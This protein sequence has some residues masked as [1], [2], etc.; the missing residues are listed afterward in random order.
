MPLRAAQPEDCLPNAPPLGV[1]ICGSAGLFGFLRDNAVFSQMLV[2]LLFAE[3]VF[4]ELANLIVVLH[5]LFFKFRQLNFKRF[6]I[7]FA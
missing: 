3:H 1:V 7:Q 6:V 5:R 4:D 2:H